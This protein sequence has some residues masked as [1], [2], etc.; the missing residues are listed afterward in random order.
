MSDLFTVNKLLRGNIG[1][2]LRKSPFVDED[3]GAFV[4]VRLTISLLK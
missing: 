4:C 2:N 3:L 1:C